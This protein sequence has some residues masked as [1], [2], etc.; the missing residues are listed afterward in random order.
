MFEDTDFEGQEQNYLSGQ[1][2]NFDDCLNEDEFLVFVRR[3][4][5]HPNPIF[6]SRIFHAVDFN[7]KGSVTFDMVVQYFQDAPWK[8]KRKPKFTGFVGGHHDRWA[9]REHGAWR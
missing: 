4:T 5:P 6:V 7:A 3:I 1:A 8:Q 9:K 2:E